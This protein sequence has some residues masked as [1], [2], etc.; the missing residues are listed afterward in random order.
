MRSTSGRTRRS[1]SFASSGVKW[2]IGATLCRRMR[3]VDLDAVT[4]DA[5]GTLVGLRDPVPALR[6]ALAARGVERTAEQ[7]RRA[8]EAEAA[9]YVERSH[10][11][12]DEATLGLLRRDCAAV[13]LD[14]AEAVLDAGA[15]AP[16]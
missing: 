13:F 10:E 4:I 2:R 14:A 12:R 9:F 7:V 1:A 16:A 3:A 15:F 11:G 6:R 8:F 5:F